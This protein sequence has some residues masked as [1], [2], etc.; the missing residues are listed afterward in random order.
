MEAYSFQDSFIEGVGDEVVLFVVFLFIT[1][2]LISLL[3]WKRST[4]ASNTDRLR[5]DGEIQEQGIE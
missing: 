3:L 4:I 2:T 5:Q 1:A